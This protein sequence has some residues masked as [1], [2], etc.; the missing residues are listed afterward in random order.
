MKSRGLRS[1]K[2]L[3]LANGKAKKRI[4]RIAVKTVAVKAEPSKLGMVVCQLNQDVFIQ[5]IDEVEIDSVLWFQISC[6]WL[7]SLDSSGTQTYTVSLEAEAAKSW[8][9]EYDNRRRI[10]ASIT[11]MLTRSNGLVNARRLGRSILSYSKRPESKMLLNLPDVSIEDLL[12]GLN[13]SVGLRQAEIFEFIRITASHQSNPL[14]AVDDIAIEIDR[15][16]S[17][18]PSVWVKDDLNILETCVIREKNDKF[19]MAAARGDMRAFEE[20]LAQGQELVA[21]HSTLGYTALHAAADFGA[22]EIV[23]KLVS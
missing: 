20:C 17:L 3:P 21:L 9:R 13:S 19:V 10:A 11:A 1:V 4:L 14:K 2:K 18:R 22:T 6:G 7:C 23:R 16:I 15:L 5:T 8:T 12:I